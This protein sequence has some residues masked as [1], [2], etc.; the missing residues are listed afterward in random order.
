MQAAK[1][2]L[3]AEKARHGQ[4]ISA[5]SVEVS[6][7]RCLYRAWSCCLIDLIVINVVLICSDLQLHDLKGENERLQREAESAQRKEAAT[8]TVLLDLPNYGTRLPPC[9]L[10]HACACLHAFVHGLSGISSPAN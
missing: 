1:E 7:K 5:V 2:E 9:M 10:V 3:Y 4:R 8:T 6:K